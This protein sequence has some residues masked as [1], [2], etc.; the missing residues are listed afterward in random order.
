[1]PSVLCFDTVNLCGINGSEKPLSALILFFSLKAGTQILKRTEDLVD[2]GMAVCVSKKGFV[3]GWFLQQTENYP[4]WNSV[5]G[6]LT[7]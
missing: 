4:Q 1:M 6:P 5:L 2:S 7:S 3:L